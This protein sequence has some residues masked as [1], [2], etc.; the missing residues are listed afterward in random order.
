MD[1]GSSFSQ[2]RHAQLNSQS[3]LPFT[4][5]LSSEKIV[6]CL[7]EENIEYRERVF[8]PDVTLWTF[9]SQVL[10]E[11]KSL[12]AAVTKLIAFKASQGAEVPSANTA[13]YSRARERLPGELISRLSCETA[14]DLHEQIPKDWNWRERPTK[15]VDGSTTTM[16]DTP[17]NQAEYPQ[18][19]T[20]KPG[21]GF[22]IARLV[23]IICC[24][25]GA[26]LDLTLGSCKGK[27]NGEHGLLRELMHNFFAG[28]IVLGDS[29]YCTFF[30]IAALKASGV[31]G[32]FPLHGARHCDFRTGERLGR[33]D[34]LV[35]WIK[36]QKPDWMDDDDYASFPDSIRVREVEVTTEHS[37][38]RSETQVL[39]T[40]FLDH[41]VTSKADLN[42]LYKRRW[43]VEIDLKAIK[44][45]MNM[46]ILRSKTPEMIRKEIWA[47]L[48]AY[49]LIRKVM[50]QAANIHNKHPRT[51]SFSLAVQ[52]I[53]SFRNAQ[54][55]CE[56]KAEVYKKILKVIASKTV[57]NRPGRRE[58]RA[59]KRR[60]KPFP[61]LQQSRQSF[62]YAC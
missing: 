61:R 25:T 23:A 22:P 39:V 9:M 16:P 59:V 13:A 10:G 58:P 7:V 24:A 17:E 4:D 3:G 37:G 33:K 29:Y 19:S 27:G 36:P 2:V 52:A 41:R 14:F 40:T 46:D 43:L 18:P 6:K 55:F 47:H 50:A 48:L 32:V 38:F 1:S 45:T 31:D 53:Q 21:V 60:P 44:T 42:D 30:L 20:Q 12:A 8:T 62:H 5:V 49:N 35:D 57:G 51:L 26:V 56:H 34:H 15:L 11:D 54:I 28:D